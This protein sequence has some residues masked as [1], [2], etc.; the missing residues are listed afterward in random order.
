MLSPK[1][2]NNWKQ[3]AVHLCSGSQFEVCEREFI[4][5]PHP[6]SYFL[7]HINILLILLLHVPFCFPRLLLLFVELLHHTLLLKLLWLF[8]FSSFPAGLKTWACS[9][10]RRTSPSGLW[11]W[12]TSRGLGQRPPTGWERYVVMETVS[13]AQF[14]SCEILTRFS[15]DRSCCCCMIDIKLG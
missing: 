6:P 12:V 7:L 1:W 14:Y 5:S 9:P 15:G 13:P 8:L 4:N 3:T 2:C 11:C 10:I